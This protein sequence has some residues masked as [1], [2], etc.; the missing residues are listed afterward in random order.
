MDN[1]R[2]T[3]RCL[4]YD[5]LSVLFPQ[6]L[7][8]GSVLSYILTTSCDLGQLKVLRLWH[9]DSGEGEDA[10]WYLSRVAVEDLKTGHT[11]V[12]REGRKE[13]QTGM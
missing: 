1:S 8:R 12:T 10:S 3:H 6:P 5:V 9:D 11:R 7:S 2:I 13:N 4:F